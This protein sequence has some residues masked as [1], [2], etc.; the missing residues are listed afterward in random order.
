[1]KKFFYRVGS[2]D[3]V[4]SVSLRFSIPCALIIKKNNLSR[5]LEEGDLLY[6]EV[7]NSRVYKVSPC[8]TLSGISRKTGVP[9][10]KIL[11]DNS[12]DYVFYPLVLL[13]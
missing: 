3:T 5:E 10:Q 9:E 8:D 12:I 7:D 1:M 11:S 6:L 4:L 2:N 13:V